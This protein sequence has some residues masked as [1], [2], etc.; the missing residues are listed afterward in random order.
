[1]IDATCRLILLA[2]VRIGGLEEIPLESSGVLSQ[3][4]PSP[5]HGAPT[6]GT[7]GGCISFRE[8]RYLT[9]MSLEWLPTLGWLL[10]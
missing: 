6:P 9:K 3:V 4:V 1:V 10:R 2:S 7:E 5:E 8:V